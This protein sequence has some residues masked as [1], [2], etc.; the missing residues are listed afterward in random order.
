MEHFR[1]IS[2]GKFKIKKIKMIYISCICFKEKEIS[3][4]SFIFFYVPQEITKQDHFEEEN[5][6]KKK[7]Y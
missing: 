4:I 5:P 7:E 6:K 3:I 1:K 2:V